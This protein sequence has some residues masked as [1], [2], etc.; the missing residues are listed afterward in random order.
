MKETTK[1]QEYYSSAPWEDNYESTADTDSGQDVLEDYLFDSSQR[2]LNFLLLLKLIYAGIIFSTM[3]ANFGINS[4]DGIGVNLFCFIII[5]MFICIKDLFFR[6]KLIKSNSTYGTRTYVIMGI[7]AVLTLFCFFLR[8][9]Y[10]IRDEDLLLMIMLVYLSS[11]GLAI[12]DC[13]NLAQKNYIKLSGFN[14][15]WMILMPILL[16]S[17]NYI[18]LSFWYTYTPII[19]FI[20]AIWGGFVEYASVFYW[21]VAVS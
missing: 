19:L 5:A 8:C 18:D 2:A 13:L 9:Y 7:Y 11:G 15:I 3:V 20:D 1:K 12:I 14:Y 17:R 10:Q 4:G 16:M 6:F 21:I